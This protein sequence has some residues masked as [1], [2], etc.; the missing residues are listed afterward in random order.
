MRKARALEADRTG[1]DEPGQDLELELAGPD[2]GILLCEQPRL[3]GPGAEDVQPAEPPSRLSRQRP[4]CKELTT[5]VQ[6][7][8]V[9]QVRVLELGSRR[10]VQ[11]RSVG[12]RQEQHD[13][14]LIELHMAMLMAA[15][16]QSDSPR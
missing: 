1:W 5:L 9:S 6:G 12:R 10:V 14:E 4:G 13:R 8:K 16:T 11:H 2:G 3:I 15:L 7:R